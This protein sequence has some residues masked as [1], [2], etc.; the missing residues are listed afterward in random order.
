MLTALLA[1][2]LALAPRSKVVRKSIARVFTVINQTQKAQLRI[3]YKDKDL[4][5]L[6]LRY[7][8]TRAQRRALSPAEAKKETVKAKSVRQN[9]PARRFALKA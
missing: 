8:K 4:M 6:D 5:P 1:C 9:F 2:M 3:Y 7:K